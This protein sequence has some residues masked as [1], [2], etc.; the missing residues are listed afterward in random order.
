MENLKALIDSFVARLFE[1]EGRRLQKIVND[2][3]RQNSEVRHDR[4]YG[5][6]WLGRMYFA[7][8][9]PT[10]RTSYPSLDFSLRNEGNALVKDRKQ[11]EEDKTM[12]RQI[13]Y[14]LIKDCPDLQ[15]IRDSLPDSLVEL[16]EELMRL[17]RLRPAG[18]SIT[19]ERQ[20]GQY[21]KM[22]DK[23]DFYAAT[24]MMY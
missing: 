18:F 5:F 7:E 22:I 2:L 8:G 11:V 12:I 14:L 6:M 19:D 20:L 1:P 3:D 9:A 17:P 13:M 24:R 15:S 23:I 10:R 16:S 21:K 4:A